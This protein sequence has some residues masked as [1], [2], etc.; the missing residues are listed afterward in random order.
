MRFE[1]PIF[2]RLSKPRAFASTQI[3]VAPERLAL[4]PGRLVCPL[5]GQEH[6]TVRLRVRERAQCVRCGSVLA[7]R[8]SGGSAAL[9]HALTGLL[10]A[11]A[12]LLLP[13]VTVDK[14]GAERVTRLFTGVEEI[15]AQGM[16]W[17]GVWVL[18]CGVVAPIGVLALLVAL[19]AKRGP[20]RSGGEPAGLRR[21]LQALEKW[22]MPEVQ[23]LAVLVAFTK[24]GTVV[25]VRLGAGFWCYVAM[26]LSFLLA[27]RSFELDPTGHPES[28]AA[29]GAPA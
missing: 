21:A 3:R 15:W 29:E 11:P 26:S 20:R 1:P 27:W 2:W 10:L 6:G 24:L 7:T 19:L 23:V 17:L 16:H 13:F 28:D 9:A 5:C 14:F 8:S 22:A 18:I 12:A 25:N 4:G